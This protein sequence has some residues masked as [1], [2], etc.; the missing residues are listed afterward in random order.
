MTASPYERVAGMLGVPS[1]LEGCFRARCPAHDDQNPSLSARRTANG[2]VLLHCFAGCETGAVVSA[3]G[4]TM[5][6]LFVS[7]GSRPRAGSAEARFYVYTGADGAPLG[8][9]VR[10]PNK[11]FLQQRYEDG[12][13][14][15]GLRGERLPLYRLPEVRAAIE[16]GKP[17]WLP[18]GEKDAEALRALGLCAT[19]N[20]GGAKAW[21]DGLADGLAGASEVIIL[22]DNDEAGMDLGRAKAK[23]LDRRQIPY[24]ALRAALD[25][26]K[27]DV[28]DHLAAGLSLDQLIEVDLGGKP[29]DEAE[30]PLG[31]WTRQTGEYQMSAS[32]GIEHAVARDHGDEQVTPL[33]NFAAEIRAEVERDDGAEASRTFELVV[34]RGG[35][36]RTLRVPAPA[37]HDGRWVEQLAAEEI[38]Y[39]RQREPLR[40]AIQLLSREVEHRSVYGHLGWRRLGDGRS[41]FLHAGGGIGAEGPL[42]EIEVQVAERLQQARLPGP[43][44]REE[45]LQAVRASLEL[46]DYGPDRL[47]LPVLGAV[48]RAP[49]GESHLALFLTGVTGTGK[50]SLAALAQAHFGA[51]FDA[52]H[53]PANFD[54]DTANSLEGLLFEAKDCLVVVDEYVPGRAADDR[55]LRATV[56]A[57]VRSVANGSG[58][59]R[60][61]PDGSLRPSRSPRALVLATG[62]D[63][64]EGQSLRARMVALHV[65]RGEL[66]DKGAYERAR[67]RAAAGA[68]AQAMSGYLAW[69][70]PQIEEIAARRRAEAGRWRGLFESGAAHRRSPGAAAELLYG[71][72]TFLRF[73][74]EVGAIDAAAADDLLRRC[75]AA[76]RTGIRQQASEINDADP[77]ERA[78]RGV[79]AMLASGRAHLSSMRGG[80]P[81][82]PRR[83]GWTEGVLEEMK[84]LGDRLGAVEGEDI[85]LLPAPTLS[86]LRKLYQGEGAGFGTSANALGRALKERGMLAS[87]RNGKPTVMKNLAGNRVACW[88]LRT[89]VVTGGGEDPEP[90]LEERLTRGD[91]K[92]L[93]SSARV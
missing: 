73:G 52:E 19:T 21:R 60:M 64:P 14:R 5:A 39:P 24:R 3:L 40:A 10:G 49:L 34:A 85:Y 4:L 91:E 47:T 9:V 65:E 37:F 75:I 56:D 81:T 42:Q 70:A 11:Q 93:A 13:W 6:D 66:A 29:S 18:E 77:V 82:E 15:N 35:F 84:P 1:P 36:E 71:L 62:E 79:A 43:G 67:A 22:V 44:E 2:S 46:A 16:A 8:R 32:G 31:Y 87:D 88:H 78:L 72:Q 53:L 12:Q 30:E 89:S 58:R 83:F 92:R 28:S 59:Q 63:A 45:L 90:I 7:S 41:V 76:L 48:Y 50:S 26:A 25:E 54:R 68:Y 80:E 69:L 20:A 55:A 51:G 27:A 33:S 57:V 74:T 17:V 61:R 86:A 23:S 38:V